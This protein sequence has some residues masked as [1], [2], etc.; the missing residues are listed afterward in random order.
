M[1]LFLFFESDYLLYLAKAAFPK[2]LV[3]DEVIDCEFR[4]VVLPGDGV[5]R[6]LV[7][8]L[9]CDRTVAVSWSVP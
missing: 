7:C 4:V 3:Q 9:L 8:Q 6:L 2:H 1:F 5:Q